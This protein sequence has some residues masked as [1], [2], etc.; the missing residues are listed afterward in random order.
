MSLKRVRFYGE[1]RRLF[2]KEW[3]LDVRTPR[4]AIHALQTQIPALAAY[5]REHMNDHFHVV[6]GTESVD[7]EGLERPVGTMEVIKFIPA[8]A[9]A[10]D[11]PLQMV[12]GVAL[13]VIGAVWQVPFLT[14]MGA[15]MVLGGISQMLA[16]TPK[17]M[18]GAANSS[19]N[20][21]ETF[22]FSGPVL[23]IGQGGCVPLGYGR[24]RIGG[25]IISAGVDVQAWQTNGFGGAAPDEV[26]TRGGDGD[27]SPWVWAV[28]P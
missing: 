12:A 22:S 15:S 1:L 19:G 28:A 6:V 10:K 24:M 5:L 2:G 26:G 21:M 8:V 14:S 23:T 9:G 4:E 18:F 25:H 20:E 27:A 11:G 17:G 3:R 7:E 13:I 16:D